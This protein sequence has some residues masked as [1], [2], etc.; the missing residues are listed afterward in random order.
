MESLYQSIIEIASLISNPLRQAVFGLD[1]W[2]GAIGEEGMC[3]FVGENCSR[4]A[5]F[6]VI[7]EV[8]SIRL[9]EY[10]LVVMLGKPAGCSTM[11]DL[12]WRQQISALERVEL[13][14][15]FVDQGLCMNPQIERWINHLHGCDDRMRVYLFTNDTTVEVINDELQPIGNARP[16]GGDLMPGDLVYCCVLLAS[17]Q[18]EHKA[19]SVRHYFLFAKS[20]N[21]VQVH[22]CHGD[23]L[24]KW[25]RRVFP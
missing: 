10:G 24:E 3:F 4:P 15:I 13:E 6:S 22:G 12:F 23:S 20:V 11:M 16:S 19:A 18:K 25:H 8:K 9:D 7:G 14:D 2:R 21:R 1:F 5:A 17:Q